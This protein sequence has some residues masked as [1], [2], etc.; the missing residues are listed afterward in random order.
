MRRVVYDIK[1]MR[2]ACVLVAASFG[3]NPEVNRQ[4]DTQDWLLSPTPDMKV[5]PIE[6]DE[7]LAQLIKMTRDARV[8]NDSKRNNR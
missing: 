1:L 3:V 4:F 2:P 7:Q 5:Y 8:K 6:S